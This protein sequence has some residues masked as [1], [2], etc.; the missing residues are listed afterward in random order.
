MGLFW[1]VNGTQLPDGVN[2]NDF[3]SQLITAFRPFGVANISWQF[4]IAR[5]F[6]DEE[7]LKAVEEQVAGASLEVSPFSSR[8]PV[9]HLEFL[10]CWSIRLFILFPCLHFST[11]IFT[12]YNIFMHRSFLFLMIRFQDYFKICPCGCGMF[13]APV[14]QM[15]PLSSSWL[16]E[17]R[18]LVH[19]SK[20]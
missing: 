15:S 20:I 18:I 10:I 14:D 13:S 1:D 2:L 4:D 7:S 5:A 6:V 11:H 9:Q 17:T 3:A 12:I 19:T 8:E 16:L